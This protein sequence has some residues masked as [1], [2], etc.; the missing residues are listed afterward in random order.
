MRCGQPSL[1]AAVSIVT[2]RGAA[3]TV[4]KTQFD[5]DAARI[6]IRY[7]NGDSPTLRLNAVLNALSEE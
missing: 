7:C 1:Q 3:A 2:H 5:A 6:R 4:P